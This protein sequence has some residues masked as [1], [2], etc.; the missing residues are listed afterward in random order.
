MEQRATSYHS[1][2]LARALRVLRHLGSVESPVTLAELSDDLDL[3]KSTLL[4]LLVVL[5]EEQFVARTGEP[6]VY[7]IGDAVL[8]IADVSLRKED[9]VE[10]VSPV[11]RALADETGLT[12]NLG[13]LSASSVLHL[14]VEEPDRALR[15]R[16][17]NGSLDHTYCT[18]LGKM[19]LAGLTPERVGVHLPTKP[20]ASF[21]P[22]TITS[23]TALDAELESIRER[24]YSIDL[25]ERDAGVICVALAVPNDAGAQVAISVA[26]PSGE[27]DDDGRARVLPVLRDT[28]ARI[29][30]NR[31]FLAA[32]R[33]VRGAY[34]AGSPS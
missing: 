3:P 31:R 16:S 29:G 22:T 9:A 23:R 27:L 14:C 10:I 24:G 1:Q 12:A 4:R 18:G 34:P 11:L 20:F 25:E 2:G 30:G 17:A 6:P 8:E 5:E 33:T 19:L 26:G 32:L 15:F 21:T 28:A 13:L 7:G